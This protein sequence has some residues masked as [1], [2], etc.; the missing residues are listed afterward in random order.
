L[1]ILTLYNAVANGGKMMKPSFVKE[2]RKEG[3]TIQQIEP[4]V[5]KEQIA[6]QKTIDSIRSMMEGVVLRGT[7][8]MLRGTEYGIAGKTGTAQLYNVQKKAYKWVNAEGRV[9]R[10]YNVT[11]VGYFPTEKPVYSCIVVISKAKGQFYSAGKV[12]APA[13]KEISDR[14]YATKIKGMIEDEIPKERTIDSS[15]RHKTESAP[16]LQSL[17]VDY[18]DCSL[19]SEWVATSYSKEDGHYVVEPVHF[20]SVRVPNVKGMNIT[21]AVYLLENNGWNIAFEGYGKVVQQSVK[22][23][24]TLQ[25]GRL[26]TLTLGKQ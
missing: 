17:G 19:G 10:D 22:P 18:T 6:S 1:Q 25:P 13:F 21:D 7:A 4:E 2:I 5:I 11:F 14:V 24:D 26:I 23:G 16:Y 8:K 3:I 12:A 20:D 15:I 9:E